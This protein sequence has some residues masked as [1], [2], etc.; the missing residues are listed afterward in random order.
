VKLTLALRVEKLGDI[1][2]RPVRQAAMLRASLLAKLLASTALVAAVTPAAAA[3]IAQWDPPSF[4]RS[5]DYNTDTNWSPVGVPTVQ[6]NFG[7][8]LTARNSVTFSADVLISRWFLPTAFTFTNQSNEITFRGPLPNCMEF[9]AGIGPFAGFSQFIN[10]AGGKINFN[11]SSA[12][13]GTFA[14]AY[15]NSGTITFNETGTAG[16]ASIANNGTVRFDENSTAGNATII[17]GFGGATQTPTLEFSRTSSAGFAAITN[18]GVVSFFLRRR[19][20]LPLIHICRHRHRA[21]HVVGQRTFATPTKN[22]ASKNKIV[23][24][25]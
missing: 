14:M 6:A 7:N 3:E 21:L 22:W 15:T 23:T 9:C 19:V 8:Q 2:H 12:S 24:F 11:G 5:T 25:S 17:N 20:R 4:G 1:M 18:N 16:N 10:Q 13:D